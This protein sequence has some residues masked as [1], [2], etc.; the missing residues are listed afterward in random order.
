VK[1]SLSLINKTPR[2]E[3]VNESGRTAAPFLTSAPDGGDYLA[4]ESCRVTPR[5]NISGAYCIGGWVGRRDGLD[6]VE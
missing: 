5:G 2:H 1:F 3:V 4:L 6:V